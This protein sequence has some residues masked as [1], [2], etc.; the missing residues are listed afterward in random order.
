MLRTA[1]KP[2][3]TFKGAARAGGHGDLRA[4]KAAR[5]YEPPSLANLPKSRLEAESGNALRPN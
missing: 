4:P 3:E 1:L 2:V 5:R